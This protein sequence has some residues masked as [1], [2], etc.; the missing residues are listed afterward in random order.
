MWSRRRVDGDALGARSWLWRGSM[1]NDEMSEAAPAP[2]RPKETG[3]CGGQGALLTRGR[4]DHSIVR[5]PFLRMVSAER[6]S[7]RNRRAS[8]LVLHF[9]AAA[10][11]ASLSLTVAA[12]PCTS[13]QKKT[14][15]LR[16]DA[17]AA[18]DR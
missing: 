4:C 16:E 6:W 14:S 7:H 11:A 15:E 18:V 5:S 8:P 1:P 17:G 9:L 2:V 3:A 12:G 13:S 10:Q